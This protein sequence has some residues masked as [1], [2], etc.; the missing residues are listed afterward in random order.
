MIS[1]YVIIHSLS[2]SLQDKLLDMFSEE[3]STIFFL[4]NYTS[5]Y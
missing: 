3:G 5:L 4:S 1:T 2:F